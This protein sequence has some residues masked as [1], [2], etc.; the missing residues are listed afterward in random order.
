MPDIGWTEIAIIVLVLVVIFGPRKIR[1]LISSLGRSTG[2]LRN[3]P[4]RND[5]DSASTVDQ[6]E[7]TDTSDRTGPR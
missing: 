4:E 6:A 7:R 1:G 5:E 2:G 3:G